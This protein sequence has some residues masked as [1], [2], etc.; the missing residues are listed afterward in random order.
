MPPP[1]ASA[2]VPQIDRLVPSQGPIYG[3]TEVSILGSGFYQGLCC[4]FGEQL[5]TT[6]YWSENTMV[7]LLPPASTPGP[8]VVS[9]KEHLLEQKEICIFTYYDASDQA[10]LELALQLV[11]MK[12]TG[13]LQ[14]AKQVA[15]GIIVQGK[16]VD[17]D[18]RNANGHTMLHLLVLLDYTDLV[19]SWIEHKHDNLDVQDTFGMTALH[20]ACHLGSLE[21]VKLLMEAGA[22]ATVRN[23]DGYLPSFFIPQNKHD[24]KELLPSP[25]RK[26]L[27]RRSSMKGSHLMHRFHSLTKETEVEETMAPTMESDGLGFVQPKLDKRLYLFWLPVLIVAIGLLFVQLMGHP[28]LL[29]PLLEKVPRRLSFTI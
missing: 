7:C 10:L 22:D 13:K 16:S 21:M 19:K 24:I 8:V 28:T 27:S 12:S 18:T 4:L 26:P 2:R 20:L 23:K 1:L 3:G 17:T 5:A 9:F 6:L 29:E 15:M 11:G 25:K 14:D